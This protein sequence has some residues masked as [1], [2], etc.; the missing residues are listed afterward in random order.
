MRSIL[1]T[2]LLPLITF[3]VAVSAQSNATIPC[4]SQ[5]GVD[6]SNLAF[7]TIDYSYFDNQNNLSYTLNIC[8]NVTTGTW[9]KMYN[10]VTPFFFIPATPDYMT[11][12]LGQL[13][14]AVWKGENKLYYFNGD[15]CIDDKSRTFTSSMEFVCDKINRDHAYVASVTK[16]KNDPCHYEATI[17]TT[18]AC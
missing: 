12:S 6:F 18:L 3:Y 16:N 2:S 9:N 17:A 14:T 7:N 5:N 8:T 13:H 11:L 4:I 15:T 1:F 10:P